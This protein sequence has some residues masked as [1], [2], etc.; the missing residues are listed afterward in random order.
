V[1]TKKGQWKTTVP[2]RSTDEWLNSQPQQ[3]HYL[4]QTKRPP[5]NPIG[6]SLTGGA[7]ENGDT[8]NTRN[9]PAKTGCAPL[10]FRASS[11]AALGSC[12]NT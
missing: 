12:R 4:P 1:Q 7:D 2:K 10:A 9:A 8:I 11:V 3:Q 6:K 5:F